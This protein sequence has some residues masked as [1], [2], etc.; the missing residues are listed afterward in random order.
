MLDCLLFISPFLCKLQICRVRTTKS[1][2]FLHFLRLF[3]TNVAINPLVSI[4]MCNRNI[5]LLIH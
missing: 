4:V 3:S 5:E 2:Y 1:M